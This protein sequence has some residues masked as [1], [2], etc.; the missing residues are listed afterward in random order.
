[1][2]KNLVQYDYKVHMQDRRMANKHN[3]FLIFFTGL[4]GS[5]KSTIANYLEQKLFAEN[6]RTYVLDGDHIRS[7]ISSDLLFNPKDRS[8]NIR[9]I[10][11]IAKLFVDAGIVVLA[12]FIA[13]YKKDRSFIRKTVG[14]ENYFEVYVNTSLEICE[15]RDVKGLY[16]RARKGEIKNLTGVSA[17]YEVPENPDIVVSQDTSVE[18]TVSLILK[19]IRNKLSLTTNA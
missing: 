19:K 14:S 9:R 13:P 7:G 18:E 8:E 12:A 3:S 5:G 10:A 17:P 16:K 6:I 11:E 4:S 1:M 15:E 2:E